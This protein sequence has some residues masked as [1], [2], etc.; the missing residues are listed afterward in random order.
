MIF[1][2]YFKIVRQRRGAVNG[3]IHETNLA[4]DLLLE[5]GDGYRGCSLLFYLY[6]FFIFQENKTKTVKPLLLQSYRRNRTRS[7][8]LA[9]W[10][11]SKAR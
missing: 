6:M 2:I 8:D 5:L 11:V 4:R 3:E 10:T 1:E 9:I 7:L